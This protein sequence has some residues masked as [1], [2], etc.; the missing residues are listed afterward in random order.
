[1]TN[2]A[3]HT[4]T[5]WKVYNRGDQITGTYA[6]YRI[7]YETPDLRSVIADIEPK[8]LCPEHG[9]AQANA[10]FIVKACNAHEELVDML[11][12]VLNDENSRIDYE[13]LILASAVL[14]K[15]QS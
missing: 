11:Q 15:V 6:R 1:M 13:T 12:F 7:E 9:D 8:W 2:T 10:A 14:A 4:P 3:Q 5:P